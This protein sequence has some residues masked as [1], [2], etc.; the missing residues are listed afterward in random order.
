MQTDDLHQIW[1]SNIMYYLPQLSDSV[2]L[3][4]KIRNHWVGTILRMV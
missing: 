3:W 1:R 4:Q 2:P